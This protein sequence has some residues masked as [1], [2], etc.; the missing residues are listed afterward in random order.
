MKKQ[1]KLKQLA[2]SDFEESSKGIIKALVEDHNHMRKLMAKIKSSR[3]TDRQI[4]TA[5]NTLIDTVNLHVKAE[6]NTF[7]TLI[8]DNPKFADNVLEG[9]EEHRVHEYVVAALKKVRDKKRKIEQMKIYCEIL[10]HHLDEEEEEL[11]PKFRKYAAPSTRRKIAHKF[12]KT[13]YAG[14]VRA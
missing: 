10:E 14:E 13:R 4:V 12:N 8:K 11:F 1:S 3:S 2:D 9:Y 5:F 6:E 7:Y